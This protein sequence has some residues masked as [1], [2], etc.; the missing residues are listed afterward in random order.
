MKV[1]GLRASRARKKVRTQAC[2]A[3]VLPCQVMQLR[4][5]VTLYLVSHDAVRRL[6]VRQ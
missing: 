6:C 4:K 1:L 3:L 5:L 2:P